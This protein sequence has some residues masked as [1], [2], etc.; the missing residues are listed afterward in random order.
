MLTITKTMDIY[1][2]E[3]WSGAVETYERVNNAGMLGDL[4][5]ILEDVYPD[6]I[7]ETGLNDLLWFDSDTVLDW[8]GLSEEE[9]EEEDEEEE[10]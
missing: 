9:E 6:G 5:A 10:D 1:D 8:L 7:D 2:F 4:D 3:P